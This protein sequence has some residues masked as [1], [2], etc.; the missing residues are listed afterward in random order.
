MQ[1]AFTLSIHAEIS[2]KDRGIELVWIAA[3]LAA[4]QRTHPDLT[5]PRLLHALRVIPEF[6]GRVLRVIYNPAVS[7]PHIVTAYFDRAMK[8][9]L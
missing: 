3:T 2:I 9:K 6:G 8:G 7:P 4:P 1:A 5:D